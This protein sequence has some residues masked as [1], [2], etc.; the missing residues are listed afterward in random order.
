M[1]RP[2]EEHPK[3]VIA[4]VPRDER[5]K[6][7]CEAVTTVITITPVYRQVLPYNDNR[8]AILLPPSFNDSI[9]YRPKGFAPAGTDAGIVVPQSSQALQLTR[10]TFGDIVCQEW[11]AATIFATFPVMI[12]S[13]LLEP[14]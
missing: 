10:Q 11:E 5:R 1:P 7:R 8:W 13:S 3:H 12:L 6:R 2:D 9:I 14:D 4:R